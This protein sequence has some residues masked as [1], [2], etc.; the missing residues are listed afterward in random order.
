[1]RAEAEARFAHA[2][3]DGKL[4]STGAEALHE[5]Q[6]HQIELEMQNDELRR[7]QLE[8]EVAREREVDLYDFAP[9]GYLTLDELGAICASNL[10]A[11]T[12]LGTQRGALIG[13]PFSAFVPA[14][15]ADRWQLFSST[16]SREGGRHACRLKVRKGDG[17]TFDAQLECEGKA[18]EIGRSQLRVVLS[19]VSGFARLEL[20]LSDTRARLDVASRLAAMGTLVAGVAHEINNPLAAELSGQGLALEVVRSVRKKLGGAFAADLEVILR[21]LDLAAE[22]LEDAQAGGQRIAR[23]VKD[24]ST[25]GRSN[26]T[27]SVL[28]LADVVEKAMRWLPQT[29][30]RS[31]TLAVEDLGPPDVMASAAQ[32]QEIILNLLTNAAKATPNGQHGE[33]ALRIGP[34]EPG[35][36]RLEVVDQGVGIE[37]EIL[38]K[39]FDPFFTTRN[40]GEG[41]GTG[42]GLAIC[43]VIATSHG[44]S[45][46]VTSELG[47]GSTFR[48]ELPALAQV[49]DTPPR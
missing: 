25:F 12:L 29:V 1:L 37:P 33:I 23:I 45:L 42:L 28:R 8:L 47:K 32:I 27:K 26:A 49:A 14:S 19:D 5:L 2:P 21:D 13:R 6:V 34:G 43:H 16:T 46:T 20:A 7:S 10:T 9:V 31:T 15:D 41:R 17:E 30:S 3:P 24:L 18:G 44:G 40:V 48:L 4:H 38:D 36:A 35:M 39:I 11:A 22:A